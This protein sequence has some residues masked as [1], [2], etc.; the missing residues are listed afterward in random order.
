M[1][2]EAEIGG[3]L[4]RGWKLAAWAGVAALVLLPLAVYFAGT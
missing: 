3:R 4:G 2:R 1:A